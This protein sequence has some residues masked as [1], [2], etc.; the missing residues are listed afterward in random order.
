VEAASNQPG[1]T[2]ARRAW[3]HPLPG[4][5]ER[6][7]RTL[8][9]LLAWID[10]ERPE[11]SALG[12]AL[13][14][15]S[16][17][18]AAPAN[19]RHQVRACLSLLEA[20]GLGRREGAAVELTEEGR[21]YAADPDPERLFERLHATYLGLL[22]TLVL[23]DTWGLGGP[24]ARRRLFDALVK[25]GVA[26]GPHAP[27]AAASRRRWLRSLGLLEPTGSEPAL[28]PLG[29]QVL[30]AHGAEVTEIRKRIEDLLE[31]E[32]EADL[33]VAE[34]MEDLHDDEGAPLPS[35]PTPLAKDR[36]DLTAA[37][38]RPHLAHLDVPDSLL[39][40][41]GAALSS[42][43]HLLLV[44]PPG[45][46]K[47]D[48]ALGLGAAAEAEGY[49]RGMLT[50]TASADWTTY[51]TIGGYALERDGA[52]RFRSGVFLRALEQDRWLLVDELNRADVDRALG[53][54]FTVLSGRGAATPFQLAD[55]RAVSVGVA[56][57]ISTHPAP[58]PKPPDA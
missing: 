47:T 9:A 6:Y 33:A 1:E 51:E 19:P 56:P 55:G 44:G 4:G 24:A 29:R 45:T 39:E 26:R 22:E 35:R 34:A 12:A 48:L 14:H 30:G 50:V 36:V 25:R 53:E 42:G 18:G 49:S 32:R 58:A 27:V 21:A 28:T 10:R 41:I 38:L 37:S 5:A 23:A 57:S 16:A 52:L 8:D 17:M 11:T 3:L 43:K 13:G 54:L 15:L 2:R 20:T 7:K 46:G 40:R 31:D